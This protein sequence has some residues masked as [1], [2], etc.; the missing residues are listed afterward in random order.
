MRH[1]VDAVRRLGWVYFVKQNLEWREQKMFEPERWDGF[2]D[3]PHSILEERGLGGVVTPLPR[4]HL[5]DP[6]LVP[7]QVRS[8][9]MLVF[10][11]G[12][13]SPYFGVYLW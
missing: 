13:S 5:R 3:P 11:C 10:S 9:V 8:N 12:D 6:A 7:I 1:T 2:G 4:L